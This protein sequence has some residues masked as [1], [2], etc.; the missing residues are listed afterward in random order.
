MRQ[1]I[2]RLR[3]ILLPGPN[4]VWQ[5]RSRVRLPC[6]D[7][8]FFLSKLQDF[9]VLGKRIWFTILE[10]FSRC[11]F[12]MKLLRHANNTSFGVCNDA[13]WMAILDQ[14]NVSRKDHQKVSLQ[15]ISM[16]QS[17]AVSKGGPETKI[18]NSA[19]GCLTLVKPVGGWPPAKQKRNMTWQ[20]LDPLKPH[21]I[22]PL[23]HFII[24]RSLL[25]LRDNW[26]NE[27][28]SFRSL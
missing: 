17:R 12:P 11:S 22:R 3:P 7:G 27:I 1:K 8:H 28:Q 13:L 26:S 9:P 16:T 6:F 24:G 18:L 2:M 5:A 25:I 20:A 19:Y 4:P 10:L 23:I 21:Q 14:R 15:R